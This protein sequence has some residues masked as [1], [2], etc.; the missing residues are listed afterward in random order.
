MSQFSVPIVIFLFKR[1]DTV[2]RILNRIKE[3]NPQKLYLI[4]DGP[5]NEEEKKLVDN[6]R[7]VVEENITWDCEVIRNYADVNKGIYDR[8]GKGAKW[9]FERERTAIFLEDD[10]LPELT[11][12]DYCRE[13]LEKYQDDKRI[14]WINGTN[15]L[16]EYLPKDGSSYMFT[17]QL[18]PCGWA[19]WSDKF[20][21]NYDGELSLFA[22]DYYKQQLEDTYHNRALYRQQFHSI[23]TTRYKIEHNKPVSWDFQM[24]FSVRINSMYGISPCR[25][26]IKN[27]G[28]DLHSEHGGSSFRNVMTRR[29]CGM[30]SKPL[31]LPLK[32][33]KAVIPDS[34]YEHKI[35]NVILWPLRLRIKLKL[36]YIYKKIFGIDKYDSLTLMFKRKS[37]RK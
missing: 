32:H 36:G 8:I 20:I 1:Y 25:N 5:R 29:F 26:Q 11:F 16:T 21:E 17:R 30:D 4:A 24:A 2:I 34:E 10:N 18:L 9:V 27:I 22:D 33:P 15:Y 14:L 28:V 37:R 35:E 7:K 19:S 6:C 12:F 3:I 23:A 13:L 31:D